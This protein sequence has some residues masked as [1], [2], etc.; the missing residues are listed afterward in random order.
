MRH[1]AQRPDRHHARH[2]PLH[3][4]VRGHHGA[5]AQPE[6]AGGRG[7]SLQR[8]HHRATVLAQPRQPDHRP[9][10]TCQ[11]HD[12]ADASGFSLGPAPRRAN[13][14]ADP[15]PRR[16][17]Q[18]PLG[19]GTRRPR[20]AA[21]RQRRLTTRRETSR[22]SLPASRNSSTRT[23]HGRSSCRW[24]SARPTAWAATVSADNR[25]RPRASR[26]RPTW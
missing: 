8:L 12:G 23:A 1:A 6:P 16:L 10:P 9:L 22:R 18:R 25:M 15:A 4:A 3:R 17:P 19:R 14:P 24:A 11:R 2:R 26:S 5:D 13:D 21:H 20:S 7:R